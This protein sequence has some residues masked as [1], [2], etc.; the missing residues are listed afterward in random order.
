MKTYRPYILPDGT[1]I[2]GHW[3]ERPQRFVATE[4]GWRKLTSWAQQNLAAC[5]R[6][7][8]MHGFHFGCEFHHK[9]G[10]GAG[11]RDDRLES[12][13][14]LCR[15]HHQETPIVTRKDRP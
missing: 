11:K 10:R 12:L 2:P 5:A 3:H 1:E 9:Y 13:E 8:T 4:Y 6:W 15:K 14:W 7:V